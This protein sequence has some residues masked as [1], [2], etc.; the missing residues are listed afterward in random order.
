MPPLCPTFSRKDQHSSS[1][2][3]KV[4]TL[5]VYDTT[6]YT[7]CLWTTCITVDRII[8]KFM[9]GCYI[10]AV[11]K[12]GEMRFPEYPTCDCWHPQC[13]Y[14]SNLDCTVEQDLSSSELGVQVT[15]KLGWRKLNTVVLYDESGRAI[16]KF[17]WS[18][19]RVILTGGCIQCSAPLLVR[20]LR[21]LTTW[22][23]SLRDGV[24][25]IRVKGST[26]RD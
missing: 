5:L 8:L 12:I 11:P 4:M 7:T 14:C 22:N 1:I 2:R 23:F 15:S 17:H 24:V 21:G 25:Q 3:S 6:Q 16:G 13:G 18:R 20:R 9:E 26:S 10:R 19:S